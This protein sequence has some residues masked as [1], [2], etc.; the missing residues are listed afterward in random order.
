[1]RSSG[2]QAGVKRLGWRRLGWRRLG[3]RR[4]LVAGG[5]GVFLAGWGCGRAEDPIIPLLEV[6][7][8]VHGGVFALSEAIPLVLHA[9]VADDVITRAEVLVN[10]EPLATAVFCCVWCP[11]ARPWAGQETTL[12]LPAVW[13]GVG[14]PPPPWRGW[15]APRAG[16][17]QVAARGLGEEGT[18][19]VAAAVTITVVDL[20]LQLSLMDDG[21]AWLVLPEGALVPGGW[22]LE[23]SEDLTNWTRLGA[24]SA[25]AVAA[26]YLD[27]PPSAPRGSRF[28]RAVYTP[29]VGP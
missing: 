1:M 14:E 7:A 29:P 18:E 20:A 12:Q 3:G 6:V 2:Q 11:C 27:P 25:G 22:N 10:G 26:F 23:V 24:F 13:D 4:L 15:R 19:V 9:A 17:Y 21:A 16:T 5:C 8:P 28:Y